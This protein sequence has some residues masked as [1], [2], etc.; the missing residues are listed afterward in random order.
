[1]SLTTRIA[2]LAT[3]IGSSVK[4]LST[5]V[6]ALESRTKTVVLTQAAYDS[7]AVKDANTAYVIT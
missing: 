3:V 4:G 2:D 7:L 1:M 5:R 6:T